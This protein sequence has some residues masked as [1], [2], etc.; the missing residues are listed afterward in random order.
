MALKTIERTMID[1]KLVDLNK[2]A[3]TNV[4]LA[5]N[6]FSKYTMVN[7]IKIVK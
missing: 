2:G 1:V 4:I 6:Y 3:L 7:V 5:V